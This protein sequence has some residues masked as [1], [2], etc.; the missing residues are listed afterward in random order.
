VLKQG[1]EDG[2]AGVVDQVIDVAKLR[3][4]FC[5]SRIRL[6]FNRYIAGQDERLLGAPALKLHGL[7]QQIG[8]DIKQRNSRT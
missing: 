4:N 1:L 5:Y 3:D 7:A 2:D 6:R 8:F